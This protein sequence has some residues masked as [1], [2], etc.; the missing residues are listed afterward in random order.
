MHNIDLSF[1]PSAPDFTL[2]VGHPSK[3]FFGPTLSL[4]VYSFS[5]CIH[6]SFWLFLSL[7][8]DISS[9]VS[10]FLPAW[11]PDIDGKCLAL[12]I[13]IRMIYSILCSYLLSHTIQKSFQ[14]LPAS[15]VVDLG[16]LQRN[17][18]YPSNHPNIT[19]LFCTYDL[20]CIITTC[21]FFSLQVINTFF[22][23]LAGA[24]SQE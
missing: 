16:I 7:C 4:P 24:V 8:L 11:H 13:Y 10:P 20:V 22:C 15:S 5:L 23:V 14:L 17:A 12:M 1:A 18:K 21:Y 6:L 9:I 2:P 19:S 3:F